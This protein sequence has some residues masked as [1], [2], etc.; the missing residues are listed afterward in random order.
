MVVLWLAME[1][2]GNDFIA[3]PKYPRGKVSQH[4]KMFKTALCA[5]A[6]KQAYISGP[7]AP[8][9]ELVD[10]KHFPGSWTKSDEETFTDA[11]SANMAYW[12]GRGAAAFN[13]EW[14]RRRLSEF[15][16][17]DIFLKTSSKSA[18]FGEIMT[19]L[20]H[21]Y[22]EKARTPAETLEK[23]VKLSIEERDRI[24][25]FEIGPCET[26]AATAGARG[27][28]RSKTKKRKPEPGPEPE[29]E[30]AMAAAAVAAIPKKR[31]K[32]FLEFE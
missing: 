14:D 15:F 12:C 6:T 8:W 19:A 4:N 20:L 2:Y 22:G 25:L 23:L 3:R 31:S 5:C 9:K 7:D 32:Y 1:E 29:L 21:Q 10:V 18:A 24:P 11:M 17:R 16:E 26:G 27:G 30:T 13:K 28:A